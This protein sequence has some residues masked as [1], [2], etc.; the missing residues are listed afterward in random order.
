MYITVKQAAD[1][2]KLKPETVT[3]MIREGRL[4]GIKLGGRV[5]RVAEQSIKELL[6][7]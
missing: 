1:Q 2:L 6:P 5:W 3:K 4:K 7:E